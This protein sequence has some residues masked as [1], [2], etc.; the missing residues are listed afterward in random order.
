[1]SY[2]IGIIGCGNVGI[3]YAFSLANQGLDINEL[4]LIDLE[5]EKTKGKALDLCHSLAFSRSYINNVK[6]G[7][8]QDIKDAD[9]IC[10][11]AGVPQSSTK[12]S[13]MDDIY[14]ASKIISNIMDDVN[15]SGFEGIILVAS[16]PLDIMTYK[17]AKLY[18]K[19]Y[20]KVIGSGTLLETARL[21]YEISNK[22]Q[23]PLKSISGYVFGEHGDT[24][25]IAWSSVKVNNTY[26]I[27]DYLTPKE[28][29]EIEDIVRKGGFTVSKMQGYT[30]YGIANALTRITRAIINDEDIEL[31]VSSYD[32]EADAYISSLSKINKNGVVENKLYDLTEKEKELYE[33]SVNFIKEGINLIEI[34]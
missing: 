30:C 21:R 23:F 16:N 3:S 8:Y 7:G 31:P 20:E 1:M 27:K 5:E 25:F 4:V 34:C 19:G 24:Q 12:A 6:Y 28:M 2:K 17:I 18:N 22:L 15:K 13:R 32:K 33:I 10:I 29:L 9:I 11:T 26:D 14:G